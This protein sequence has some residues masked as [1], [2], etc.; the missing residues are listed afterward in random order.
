MCH[1]RIALLDGLAQVGYLLFIDLGLLHHDLD[2]IEAT[3]MSDH[4]GDHRLIE[5][6]PFL[7]MIPR[8]VDT[9]D[10]WPTVVM[11]LRPIET[12]HLT[13]STGMLP[14]HDSAMAGHEGLR[15]PSS[16]KDGGMHRA[17]RRGVV[18][19]P[20]LDLIHPL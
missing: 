19:G 17:A 14:S 12:E 6:E 7:D 20:D 11:G 2:T 3:A 13:S 5:R 9:P 15:V 18:S 8:S 4:S 16:L 10:M 1:L